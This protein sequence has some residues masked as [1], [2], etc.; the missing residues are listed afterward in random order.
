MRRKIREAGREEEE[1]LGGRGEGW[2]EGGEGEGQGNGGINMHAGRISIYTQCNYTGC[3][4]VKTK[5][6]KK[7]T[8]IVSRVVYGQ[9]TPTNTESHF[10]ISLRKASC[11]YKIQL[12]L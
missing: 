12:K 6:G 4:N 10:S 3:P 9:I 11:R 8:N 2:E 7:N 1:V 5:P